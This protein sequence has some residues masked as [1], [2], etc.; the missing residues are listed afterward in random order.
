MALTKMNRTTAA[1][2]VL[3]ALATFAGSPAGAQELERGLW[4]G[5]ITPPGAPESIPVMFI[6]TDR[7]GALSILMSNPE[8]GPMEFTDEA[9]EGD[10]L[11]FWWNTGVRVD[12]AL[13]RQED[14]SFTGPCADVDGVSGEG[15]ITMTPPEG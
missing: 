6:V 9:L 8:R 14:G 2:A 15:T 11:T 5:A 13:T 4:T 1:A 7:D 12:C 3:A 10:E